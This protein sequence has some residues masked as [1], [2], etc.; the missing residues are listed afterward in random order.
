MVDTEGVAVV[1]DADAHP[2]VVWPVQFV[3]EGA[4]PAGALREDLVGVLWRVGHH[5]EHPADEVERH[6]GVEEIA[7]RV[8]EDQPRRAPRVGDAQGVLV[9]GQGEARAACARVAVVAVL[10]LAHG[11]ESLGERER[12]AVVAARRRAVAARGRV[13]RRLCP[14]D[15]GTVGHSPLPNSAIHRPIV[16]TGC[17]SLA[18]IGLRVNRGG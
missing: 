12:V 6:V 5:L 15:A 4:Q 17:D 18:N 9:D 10:G 11:L 14:L 8:D 13:P 3:G 16:R 1:L 7:H 2:D